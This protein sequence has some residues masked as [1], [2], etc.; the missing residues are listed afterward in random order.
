MGQFTISRVIFH[1]YVKLPEGIAILPNYIALPPDGPLLPSR[2]TERQTAMDEPRHKGPMGPMAGGLKMVDWN[3]D[4]RWDMW[5]IMEKLNYFWWLE[6]N[7]SQY[8]GNHGDS[9]YISN[10]GSKNKQHWDF[11]SKIWGFSMCKWDIPAAKYVPWLGP[12][13][14]MESQRDDGGTSTTIGWCQDVNDHI[15]LDD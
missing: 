3:G 10:L 13:V 2:S 12:L 9:G 6:I 4:L 7:I 15:P 11:T 8:V 1:S 5:G 14:I